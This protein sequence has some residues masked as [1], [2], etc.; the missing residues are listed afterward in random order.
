MKIL[1]N[2]LLKKHTTF[3][4]GG[5]ARFFC[6]ARNLKDIQKAINFAKKEKIKYFILG[7][8]SNVLFSDKGFDGLVIKLCCPKISIKRN[9]QIIA[10]GGVNLSKLVINAVEKGW[11]GLEELAGIPGTVGGAIYGNAGLGKNGPWIGDFVEKIELLMPNG[12]TKEVG[13]RWM[14]FSYRHS[15]LKEFKDKKPI[16]LSVIFQLK[17]GDG[18]EMK[19]TIKEKASMRKDKYPQKPS[20]GCIFKNPLENAAAFFIDKSGLKGKKIGGAEIS[21]KH[22]NFIVNNGKAKAEDILKLIDLIKKEV[23][24]KFKINLEEEVQII[25]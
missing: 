10:D 24:K 15:K 11:K 23:K 18:K 13:N 4:V 21:K 25:K 22:A 7:G 6:E 3:K 2:E 19:E 20:S 5:P 8:G 12:T 9:G 14:K 1:E 16:V 17:K